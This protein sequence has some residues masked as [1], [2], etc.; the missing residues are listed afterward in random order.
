V[1]AGQIVTFQPGV[2]AR[3]LSASGGSL[4]IQTCGTPGSVLRVDAQTHKVTATIPAGGG[5]C[6]YPVG[7]LG[8][9]FSV[10]A[11]AEGVWVIDSVNGTVGR[12]RETTNQVDRPIRVGDT[13][14]AVAVGLGAVWVAVDGKASPSP[15]AS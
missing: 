2:I 5:V 1:A 12:I 7:N 8:T 14:T 4:W 10:A 11:G 15:S 3:A 6:P 9:P 13:T